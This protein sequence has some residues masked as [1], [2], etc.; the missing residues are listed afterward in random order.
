MFVK[1]NGE[2]VRLTL[3]KV[4]KS[5]S[6][7]VRKYNLSLKLVIV[8][9]TMKMILSSH[10]DYTSSSQNPLLAAKLWGNITK[11]LCDSVFCRRT[12]VA[13]VE[14]IIFNSLPIEVDSLNKQLSLCDMLPI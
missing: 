13:E 5:L 3:S 14:K 11:Y 12:S 7:N 2:S 6:R 8:F 9:F 4:T 10:R 1:Y